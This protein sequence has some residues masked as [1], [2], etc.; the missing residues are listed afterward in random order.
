[1]TKTAFI[2]LGNMGLGMCHNLVKAGLDVSAFDLDE[3][4]LSRAAERGA[5]AASSVVD[6]VQ[7]ADVIVTM[8]PAG[9]HVSD[10]LL[11]PEGAAS[12]APKGALF[13][14]CSTIAVDEARTVSTKASA[15]G[16]EMV[17]APVS[18]GTAAADAGTL[19]FMVGG[20]DEAFARAK[21]VLEAMGAN[22]FH[23]GGTGNGQVA[24]VANNM[25]L[26]ISM[27]ATSEAF[28]LAGRLGL[29]AQTF[30]DISSK[31]SGQNWSMT[32]YC[33]AP[34]PVPGAPSNNDYKPGF[35]VDMMLKDLRLAS[36][37][38]EEVFADTKLGSL[39]SRI[40]EE[41]SEQGHGGRDFSVIMKQLQGNL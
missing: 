34:G 25:L 17:D 40:Y 16:F 11:G 33:P 15:A 41:L 7:N 8:L 29:D 35:A 26:G 21:P 18:G 6:A 2:G 39:A 38:A 22:I 10:V 28:D 12:G 4:A 3:G 20:S 19:T 32:K 37:A 23:A 1:M 31:A 24:K 14:D 27:I 30:F 9:K 13:I 5:R 36:V